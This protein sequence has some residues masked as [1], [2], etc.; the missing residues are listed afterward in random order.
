MKGKLSIFLLVLLS[1]LLFT[2]CAATPAAGEAPPD[3]PAGY[4]QTIGQGETMFFFE[5]T[6][7][8][9]AFAAWEVH[10]DADTVGAALLALGL[11]A[12]AE[13]EWGL[14]VNEVNG[15]V[16][17]WDENQSFWAFYIGGEFAMAGID[18]TYIEPGATYALVYTAG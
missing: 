3:S 15:V 13:S 12:G 7:P 8:D 6:G 1:L 18:A 14:M 11:I 16:A 4:A 10:T 5:T 17:D 9:G 2:A